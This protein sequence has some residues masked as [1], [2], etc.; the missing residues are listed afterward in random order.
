[1]SADITDAE[2]A[3][4]LA[5]AAT[6]RDWSG[7]QQSLARLCREVQRLRVKLATAE[8]TG[9]E[10]ATTSAHEYLDAAGE[11]SGRGAGIKLRI[12]AALKRAADAEALLAE[13]TPDECMHMRETVALRA[14][15]ADV[16]EREE[17][18]VI[19]WN[20]EVGAHE[21]TRVELK[22][23]RAQLE[24]AQLELNEWHAEYDHHEAELKPLRAQLAEAEVSCNRWRAC[25]AAVEVERNS[26]RAQLEHAHQ[27][28]A[29]WAVEQ[30][31]QCKRADAAE[32]Q[33]A[34][35]QAGTAKLRTAL[36]AAK[37]WM[38]TLC[39]PDS[40]NGRAYRRDKQ[41]VINALATDAGAATAERLKRL[42]RVYDAAKEG[43]MSIEC[44]ECG[45]GERC[46]ICDE[47]YSQPP[48]SR[49]AFCSSSFHC[50]HDCTWHGGARIATCPLHTL[51]EIP[52]FV[53]PGAALTCAHAWERHLWERGKEYCPYCATIRDAVPAPTPGRTSETEIVALAAEARDGDGK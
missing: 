23:V 25:T 39:E 7:Y 45:S 28:G 41:Q 22:S 44:G 42:E 47:P 12:D 26:L 17:K 46:R 1:M 36:E 2:I 48:T 16:R 31:E 33:L 15:L 32:A 5:L 6:E 21:Q 30:G 35:E 4:W 34:R 51:R 24:K 18:A 53:K 14:Q 40:E 37:Q 52:F 8:D 11:T 19:A 27:N 20:D 50:C 29:R 38:M 13:V 43:M 9:Y 10:A 3:E 49:A